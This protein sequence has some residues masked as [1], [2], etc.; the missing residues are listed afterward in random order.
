MAVS[1]CGA[2]H[3]TAEPIAGSSA[4]R[5]SKATRTADSE[6]DGADETDVRGDVDEGGSLIGRSEPAWSKELTRSATA[7]SG[8]RS[9]GYVVGRRRSPWAPTRPDDGG[10]AVAQRPRHRLAR[11]PGRHGDARI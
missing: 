3:R 8:M 11:R 4:P 6:D 10:R 2:T 1:A 7:T 5:G 9:P